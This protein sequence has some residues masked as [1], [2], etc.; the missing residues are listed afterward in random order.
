MKTTA[1]F[2][3][4]PTESLLQQGKNFYDRSQYNDAVKVLQQAISTF[5]TQADRLGKA[6]AL[7]NLSLAYQQLGQWHKAEQAL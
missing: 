1:V 6:I 2:S 7:S 3:A 4:T 5:E